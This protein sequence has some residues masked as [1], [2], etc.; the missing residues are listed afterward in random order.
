[1]AREYAS[2]RVKIWQDDDWRALPKDAQLLYFTLL[3]LP[4]LSYC[5]VID[6][7]PK[8]IQA[9]APDWSWHEI[10]KA[11]GV[12]R[13]RLYL[14][15]DDETEEALI[16]S[17]IRN[18][19]LM[20]QP[21]MAVSMAHAYGAVGSRTIQG[22]IVNELVRLHQEFPDLHGWSKPEAAAL[23]SARSVN[24]AGLGGS[25]PLFGP[26]D[27]SLLLSPTPYS[28]TN[29][30]TPVSMTP[31]HPN[32]SATPPPK[33]GIRVP[34]PFVIS[35]AMKDWAA[36]ETPNLDIPRVTE[37]FVDYWRGKSGR[38]GTKVDWPATWRNWMRTESERVPTANGRA[39]PP[40][41]RQSTT[42]Q[43]VNQTLDLARQYAAQE[44]RE[45]GQQR[46]EIEA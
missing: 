29:H 3:T 11:A 20:K 37:K 38:D 10:E 36:T 24:P 30:Q 33:K 34:E 17:F 4:Q 12:L 28:S 2:I 8:K 6:W 13:E 9:F 35:D 22:V 19:G 40:G 23:L 7:R 43:R 16:R 45:A 31:E 44:A 18:D 42:D 41:T 26:N 25:E 14:I 46:M 21:R 5:G 32:A 1:M 15:V 39:S 27:S